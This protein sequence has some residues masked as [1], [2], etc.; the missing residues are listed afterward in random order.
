MFVE[1]IAVQDHQVGQFPGL[2]GSQ[3]LIEAD[4]LRTIDGGGTRL[5]ILKDG[6]V[7]QE[8][9]PAEIYGRPASIFVGQFLGSPP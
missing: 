4:D 1:P 5:V 2:D 9:P 6:R 8:G 7:E 3:I